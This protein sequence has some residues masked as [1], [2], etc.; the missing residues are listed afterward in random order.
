MYL[1]R[2]PLHLRHVAITF[3]GTFL[4]FAAIL[5][6]WYEPAIVLQDPLLGFAWAGTAYLVAYAVTEF[7]RMPGLLTF[8]GLPAASLLLAFDIARH[9]NLM[10]QGGFLN[11]FAWVPWT[12]GTCAVSGDRGLICKMVL[13]LAG[14][15]AI[16]LWVVVS[17]LLVP[18]RH[19]L[20]TLRGVEKLRGE[21]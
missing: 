20:S 6:R 13:S 3:V 5:S 10:A 15:P 16:V 1:P 14:N 11:N 9:G 21:K 4:F 12:S 17:L 18:M 2:K 8:L 19:K 7:V